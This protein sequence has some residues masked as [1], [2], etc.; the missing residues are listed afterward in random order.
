MESTREIVKVV[1]PSYR[2]AD[3][4]RAIEIP[5]SVV[6]VPESE[7]DSYAANYG[8]D[9][10]VAHPDSIIGIGPKRQWIIEQFK[11]VFMIDDEYDHLV[12]CYLPEGSEESSHCTPEETY[13]IIQSTAETAKDLGTYLFGF[14][15][16]AKP[17]YFNPTDPFGV[18]VSSSNLVYYGI[19]VLDGGGIFVPDD[20]NYNEDDFISLINAYYHRFCLIN[21]RFCEMS[22]T[23]RNVGGLSEYRSTEGE[24]EAYLYLKRKFGS[25]VR[26]K[27]QG[28]TNEGKPRKAS[29]PYE[30]V[31][32]LPF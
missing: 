17:L 23:F 9:R 7:F 22:T 21:Y 5:N 1:I 26:R 16:T 12:R 28:Y 10:V 32:N 2:R 3:K 15:K 19:G 4:V 25:A 13:E 8:K 24:K 31:L 18:S 20:L 14:S 11:N 6:C 30:R 27:G 29:S